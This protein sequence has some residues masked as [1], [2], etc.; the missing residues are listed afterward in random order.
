MKRYYRGWKKKRTFWERF[1]YLRLFIL[2]APDY[3]CRPVVPAKKPGPDGFA[4]FDGSKPTVLEKKKLPR[5]RKFIV[6]HRF[7]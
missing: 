6:E 3:Q 5:E 4:P 2:G 7:P 1:P